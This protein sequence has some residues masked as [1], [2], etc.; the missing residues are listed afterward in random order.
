MTNEETFVTAQQNGWEEAK[1]FFNDKLVEG[2]IMLWRGQEHEIRVEMPETFTGKISLKKEDSRD[3]AL[4]ASPA[5]DVPVDPVDKAFRWKVTSVD[6]NKS[7][8][9]VLVFSSHDV[10]VEWRHPCVVRSDNL[11]DDWG[12]Q[13]KG[14]VPLPSHPIMLRHSWGEV[15]Y[16]V[17]KTGANA[18]GLRMSYR[19]FPP[20]EAGDV[21]IHYV[22][23]GW[24]V[25]AYGKPVS[26][27][28]ELIVE[29]E[30]IPNSLI[31]PCLLLASNLEAEGEI[32]VGGKDI[33][34][35]GNIYF[36]D[37]PVRITFAP[38]PDSLIKEVPLWLKGRVSPPLVPGDIRSSPAF[39]V[40][41]TGIYEWDITG[42]NRSGTFVLTLWGGNGASSRN[43]YELELPGKLLSANLED[44][45][46]VL[47]NGNPPFE[48][49]KF[50]HGNT[51]FL[52]LRLKE[53]SPLEGQAVQLH[54]AGLEGYNPGD[55]TCEPGFDLP[56]T[57]YYGWNLTAV[58]GAGKFQLSL[59]GEGMDKALELPIFRLVEEDVSKFFE[60][61]FDGKTLPDGQQ[62]LAT[63]YGRHTITLMPK[64]G[65]PE[66]DVRLNWGTENPGLGVEVTPP[67]GVAQTVDRILGATWSLACLGEE[68]EF[69]VKAELEGSPLPALELPVSLSA[70]QFIMRFRA[71]GISQ[72]LPPASTIGAELFPGGGWGLIPSVLVTQG[73]VPVSG[74]KVEFITPDHPIGYGTTGDAGTTGSSVPVKYYPKEE[75]LIEFLARTT[76]PTGRISMIR[77]LVKLIP[78][79]GTPSK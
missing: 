73:G 22:T 79:S 28:F 39:D 55:L 64:S 76:E 5:F 58:Q 33:S 4:T 26:G 70:G 77:L 37:R 14:N 63:R 50:V 2:P 18:Q 13:L 25:L 74:V 49:M 62:A 29:E 46:D 42:S 66:G 59:T 52:K 24:S 75:R 30:G 69:S 17:N 10:V 36:R 41:Q 71:L 23:G 44:E 56:Q 51:Y 31:V 35:M 53:G 67:I 6:D 65:A 9:I 20:L 68:G 60:V 32:K 47:I 48:G 40:K 16:S 45:A 11:G 27:R 38:N 57:S 15:F 43:D 7:G 8:N 21:E 72:P 1:F 3:L 54:C 34:P 61:R 19:I 78:A 12:L